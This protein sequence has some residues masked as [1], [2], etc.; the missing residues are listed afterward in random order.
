MKRFDALDSLRGVAAVMVALFHVFPFWA[1][2]LMLDFFFVLSGFIL[3]HSYLYREKAVGPIEFMGHRL[4]RMYPLH[5]YTLITF[6]LAFYFTQNQLP[7]YKD[8]LVYTLFQQLTL[9]Q[10]VGLH[11][12]GVP[13]NGPAWSISVEIW[14]NLLFILYVSLFS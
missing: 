1:G 6:A 14:L 7:V 5:V 12:K 13:W 11:S 3:S 8:G 4:A 10:N 2:Y 9:T